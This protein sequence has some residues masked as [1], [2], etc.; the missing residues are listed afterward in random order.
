MAFSTSKR[1]GFLPFSRSARA[2]QEEQKRLAELLRARPQGL[3]YFAW[4]PRVGV[5]ASSR[6]L[7]ALLHIEAVKTPDDI[8]YA[9]APED[10]AALEGLWQHLVEAG[11][12]FS[13]R[14]SLGESDTTVRIS[15]RRL[16]ESA[17]DGQALHYI[18]WVQDVRHE[19]E[20]ENELRTEAQHQ[21]DRREQL[22]QILQ[23]LP[24][25]AWLRDQDLAVCWCNTAYADT[26][27][28]S[29]D[30]IVENQLE[31]LGRHA[32]ASHKL[33]RKA[34]KEQANAS[35]TEHMIIDGQ[36]RLM[37]INECYVPA[38]DQVFGYAF[39]VTAQEEA[40][41][42]L[43]RFKS[44]SSDLLGALN[45]GI[46]IFDGKQ[47]LDFFNGAFVD[48]WRLEEKWL[49]ARPRLGELLD[50]LREQRRLP[51]QADFR[52]FKR[53]WLEMFTSLIQPHEDMLHLP[54]GM[55]IRLLVVPH[56]LGGLFMI[57]EDVTSRLE[58]E[59]SVNTLLAVQRETLDNLDEGLAVFGADGQLKLSN[60]SYAKIWGLPPEAL[61]NHPHINSLIEKK[62]ER[63]APE[64]WES[65]R[66]EILNCTLHRQQLSGRLQTK[67]ERIISYN[68]ALMPD[69]GI[70]TRYTDITDSLRVEQALLEKNA[71]LEEAER[72]KVDFLANVSYQLRT[73]LNAVM[74]FAEVL[75][76]EYFGPLNKKQHEYVEGMLE[77]GDKL[78]NLVNDILDLSTIEAGYMELETKEINAEA[79]LRSLHDL[80]LEW[81]RKEDITLIY[82]SSLEMGTLQADETRL[83]QALLNLINNAI[84]YTPAGGKIELAAERHDDS[85]HLIVR[86]NGEG[87]PQD[88]MDTIMDPF[89]QLK[90]KHHQKGAGL[91]LTLTKSIIEL[92]G[93][94]LEI[95]SEEGKGTEVRC[96]L[97]IGK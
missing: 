55:A 92:H 40:L 18:F 6:N 84:R 96:V 50:K 65:T 43:K 20:R 33:A 22:E 48:L 62:K 32:K 95:Q 79:M 21:Y 57:F 71:A 10:T 27:E 86:D 41:N 88:K 35:L 64:L 58:L 69:G 16:S 67:G 36:R 70:L 44:A 42:E 93:G 85:I 38:R 76:Q 81:T 90:D 80:V 52:N 14:A 2:R 8:I 77:A 23:S 97:P 74:G 82:T 63:I 29:V 59:S 75:S 9:L 87:I 68:N 56:P 83:K 12:S 1:S 19:A 94:T 3:A 34:A 11:E 24:F 30:D 26:L 51:E 89:V 13:Y 61:H 28:Q 49:N 91:G 31:L 66:K 5:L 72:L 60:P 7:S 45:T 46:A 78:L 17:N 73:P 37:Q 39:D 15:A 54:D 53:G 25:P 47:E 4:N